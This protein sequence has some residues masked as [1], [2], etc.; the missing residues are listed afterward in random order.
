M[1]LLL[2][3]QLGCTPD[4]LLTDTDENSTATGALN[5]QILVW[6]SVPDETTADVASHFEAYLQETTD[7]FTKIHPNVKIIIEFL[8]EDEAIAAFI[9]QYRQGFGPD[10][11]YT[12][13]INVPELIDTGTIRSFPV[14]RFNLESYRPESLKKVEV[15]EQLFALP[16]FIRTQVLCYNRSRISQPPQTLENLVEQSSKGYSVGI[17]SSFAMTTWGVGLFGSDNDSLSQQAAAWAKW[18]DWLKQ[19]R[20]APNIVLSRDRQSL[21]E[22]FISG[23]LAFLACGSEEIPLLRKELGPEN[24]GV[25]FLPKTSE[26]LPTPPQRVTVVVFNGTSSTNQANIAIRLARFLTNSEQQKRIILALQSIASVNKD[27]TIDRRL[28]PIAGTIATQAHSA[29]FLDGYD[30]S[31]IN[32]LIA[33]AEP[34]YEK[35]ISGEMSTQ[36]A[37]QNLQQ[38]VIDIRTRGDRPPVSRE[39]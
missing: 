39:P 18:L 29:G 19:A 10:I 30:L 25:T 36:E 28:Y 17:P 27:V 5:G 7:E 12:Y 2:F 31:E 23:K 22:A 20:V 15:G 13:S 16:V 26:G 21:I 34:I 38:L 32:Q 33:E 9:D 6:F 3:L 35:A 24:F 8:A 4:L 37:A 14:E 11:L 1:F